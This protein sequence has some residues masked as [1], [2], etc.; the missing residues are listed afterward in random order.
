[1]Q[2]NAVAQMLEAGLIS[3][4]KVGVYESPGPQKVCSKVSADVWMECFFVNEP[5]ANR[6]D[7][8]ALMYEPFFRY[9]EWSE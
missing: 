1:M 9:L 6:E 8:D 5:L 2:I 3:R 4:V 7:T